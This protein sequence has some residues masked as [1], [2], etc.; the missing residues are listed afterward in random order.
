MLE[1]FELKKRI[2]FRKGP[3][4]FANMVVVRAVGRKTLPYKVK[5]RNEMS[6]L[7]SLP[8]Q[9]RILGRALRISEHV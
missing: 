7:G 1:G 8:V 5:N 9:F 2:Y 6:Q 4:G 3:Q